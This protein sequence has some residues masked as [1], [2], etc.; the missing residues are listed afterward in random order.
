MIAV[1]GP[2]PQTAA[3][4]RP[5]G[6]EEAFRS[7][8]R[9]LWGICYRMTGSAADADDL[10]QET[11]TRAL[12]HPPVHTD[13]AWR[14]WLVR[15][16]MNLARDLLRR[17]RRRACTGPWLPSP[18]D[19][20]DE[21]SPPSIEPTLA[22]G[23]ST[24]GRYDLLES[25]TFAFLLALEALSPQQRAVLLLRDVFD[26]SVLEVAEALDLSEA[27]VK[28]THHRAR[29]VMEAYDRAR[30]IPTRALQVETLRALE[31][32]TA[33]LLQQ[34]AAAAEALLAQGVR[35]V[36]DGG[37]EFHAAR[38]PIDGPRRVVQVLRKLAAINP[39]AAYTVRLLNG[40]PAVVMEYPRAKRGIA[41]RAVFRCDIDPGG[42]IRAL[43]SVLATAKMTAVQP[44]E[45]AV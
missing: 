30:C 29:K 3:G 38:I 22:H 10:V 12:E 17:R 25:V 43:H 15:V 1:T 7:H 18:I 45:A 23:G 14:P 36:N 26:Y 11:F 6:Y 44:V 28:T 42:R 37:G 4:A 39:P 5:K 8:E 34:D 32:L 24:E 16:A 31:C 21:A 27:N 40:L 41:P 9:F 19:T 35:L 20:G 2:A 33:S 13:L